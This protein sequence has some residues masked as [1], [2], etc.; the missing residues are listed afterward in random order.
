MAVMLPE[1]DA[2]P[3]G[4]SS[5]YVIVTRKRLDTTLCARETRAPTLPYHEGASPIALRP[6]ARTSIS[7]TAT[8]GSSVTLAGCTYARRATRIEYVVQLVCT[9]MSSAIDTR[10][11]WAVRGEEFI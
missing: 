2:H 9:M 3:G 4:K 6:L 11:V 7:H 5:D 1:E 8:W 10:G